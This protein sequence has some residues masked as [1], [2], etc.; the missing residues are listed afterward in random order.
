MHE[1]KKLGC[2]IVVYSKNNQNYRNHYLA[3]RLV[4]SDGFYKEGL[5]K[6]HS[7][8]SEGF[9][10]I[11]KFIKTFMTLKNEL[12]LSPEEHYIKIL[13]VENYAFPKRLFN[14]PSFK[15]H[16]DDFYPVAILPSFAIF[17]DPQTFVIAV[18][19]AFTLCLFVYILAK[20]V[21]KLV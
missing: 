20:E 3:K 8:F 9:Y 15:K 14:F 5:P 10:F 19:L 18:V 7:Q 16:V 21:L 1:N 12:N 13:P 11:G 4:T 17:D 6:K 2:W